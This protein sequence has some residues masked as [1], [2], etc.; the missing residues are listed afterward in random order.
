MRTGSVTSPVR[1]FEESVP[2]SRARSVVPDHEDAALTG[3]VERAWGEV[4]S[5]SEAPFAC[6]HCGLRATPSAVAAGSSFRCGAKSA[7][8]TV[9]SR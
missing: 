7:S 6:P 5:L 3:Y 2:L 4:F 9:P 8:E 1:V